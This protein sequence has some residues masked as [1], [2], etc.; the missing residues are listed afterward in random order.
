MLGTLDRLLLRFT[1]LFQTSNDRRSD[2]QSVTDRREQ[3]DMLGL[4]N[5]KTDA[6]W[7]ARSLFDPADSIDQVGWQFGSL[8]GD[9]RD[10][11]EIKKATRSLCDP[12]GSLRRGRRRDQLDQ[13]EV[14]LATEL[15]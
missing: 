5:T 4:G 9:S 15:G 7:Q 11:H 2:D 10:A 14:V 12:K 3:F 1:S 6:D 8:P 13:I